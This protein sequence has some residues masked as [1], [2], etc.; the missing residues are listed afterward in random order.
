MVTIGYGDITPK[1]DVE[2]IYAIFKML[3]GS[4]MFNYSINVMGVI[5]TDYE[6]SS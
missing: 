3:I 6:K 4:G 2:K 5:I 1:N